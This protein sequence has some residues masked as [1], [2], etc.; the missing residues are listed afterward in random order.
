MIMVVM[1]VIVIIL[2]TTCWALTMCQGSIYFMAVNPHPAPMRK[3]V[4]SHL[5]EEEAKVVSSK[6]S[7]S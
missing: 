7:Y 2:S 3:V 5:G 4:S 1:R 6:G